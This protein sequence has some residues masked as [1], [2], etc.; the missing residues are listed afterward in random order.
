MQAAF[1]VVKKLRLG[2]GNDVYFYLITAPVVFLFS[3]LTAVAGLGAAFL[4]VPFFYY[5]GA[6]LSEAAPAAL[7]LN[8]MSLSLASINYWRSRLINWRVALPI[9]A[10][11]TVFAPIG[12]LLTQHVAPPLANFFRVIPNLSWCH[13]VVLPTVSQLSKC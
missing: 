13:D 11:A 2:L 4:F 1:L 10:I 6:P 12:A 7:L 8:A 9:A 5:L 3:G